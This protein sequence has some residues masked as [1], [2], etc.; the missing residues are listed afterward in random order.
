MFIKIENGESRILYLMRI[1]VNIIIFSY[2]IMY[3]KRTY[4]K[5]RAPARKARRV[6]RKSGTARKSI[7]K[8]VKSVI[9]RQ[10]ENKVWADYGLNQTIT[11]AAGTVPI[12]KNLVPV[13]NQTT[14]SGGRVGNEI[15]VK[16]GYIRGHV[17]LL[18]Y[19]A[20]TNSL[21]LPCYV[22]MWIVS[23]RVLNTINLSS[24][25]ISTTYFDSGAGFV[26]FQ[27]N[28]L[29]IDF[30]VNKDAWIVHYT[31]TVKLGVGSTSTPTAAASYFDNSPMSAPFSFNFGKKLG[32]I[33]YDESTT[34]ATN[35]N[36]FIVFQVVD[37][38]GGSA[39]GQIMAEFHY[40]TRV[41]YEDF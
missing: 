28:M 27:G 11:S 7:V 30:S 17:N 33:K 37:A 14:S 35:K 5:R 40:T 4:R 1:I 23:G 29:D 19:N 39:G 24:T 18:P 8:I 2:I 34:S 15:R 20:S 26:G 22:K 10:A 32:N 6:S 36:M 41:E 38:A 21:A 12:S 16:N 31:K 13:L 3:V 25:N 9:S